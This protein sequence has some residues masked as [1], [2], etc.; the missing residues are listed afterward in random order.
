M[1]TEETTFVGGTMTANEKIIPHYI[2]GSYRFPVAL[3]FMKKKDEEGYY[4]PLKV[5]NELVYI[6]PGGVKVKGS[7]IR[8]GLLN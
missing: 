8:K 2:H 6:L 1:T 5:D 4:L 3:D 7:Q